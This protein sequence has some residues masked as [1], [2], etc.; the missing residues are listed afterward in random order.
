MPHHEIKSC[1]KCGKP[2]ECKA[3]NITECQCNKIYLSNEERIYIEDKFS[4]CL[5]IDC[6]RLLQTEYTMLRKI[7]FGI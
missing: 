5:C 4:D 7:H 1:C 2:F 3:G 6:L